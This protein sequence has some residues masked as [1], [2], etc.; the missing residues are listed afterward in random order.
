LALENRYRDRG[1]RLVPVSL[2]E[3]ADLDRSV[4]PFLR[5]WFPEFR[6]YLRLTPDMDGMVSVVDPAWNELLPTSYVI[7]R[8]GTVRVRLQGGKP[9]AAFEVE[10]LP[11]LDSP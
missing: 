5:K 11:L 10:I 3:P 4:L 1:L 7:D 6:S 8:G 9:R 2:D